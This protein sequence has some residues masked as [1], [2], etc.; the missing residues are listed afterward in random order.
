MLKG[1]ELINNARVKS[2]ANDF[3]NIPVYVYA[4]QDRFRAIPG[5]DG[6]A[7]AHVG[8][9]NATTP[10]ATL[11]R[12]RTIAQGEGLEYVYTGNVHDTEGG[13]TYCPGCRALLIVRDWYAIR[14]YRVD[15]NGCC[16]SK[17][18]LADVPAIDCGAWMSQ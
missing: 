1:Q 11:T 16:L 8:G 5:D 13:T 10:A 4:Y 18:C 6:Q 7:V 17:E 14:A 12:A 2:F 9:V 15:G 3:R